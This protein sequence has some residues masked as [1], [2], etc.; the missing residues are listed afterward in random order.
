MSRAVA[1]AVAM[2]RRRF[3]VMAGMVAA[4]LGL[5]GCPGT[6]GAERS[7]AMAMTRRVAVEYFP[8]VAGDEWETVTPA[9]AG[10]DAGRLE[11]A[12]TFAAE[13][14]STAMVIVWGGRIMAERYWRDWDLHRA[15]AI[16]SCQ[17]SITSV[18]A[19]IAQEDGAL[20]IGDRVTDYLGAGW[21]DAPPEA[22]NRITVRHLLTMTSGLNDRLRYIAD[23]GSTWYY[24]TPAYYRTKAVIEKAAGMSMNDYTRAKLWSRI[25]MQD[26]LWFGDLLGPTPAQQYRAS[27]RDMAR[28]GL[29]ILAG[30]S[31]AG[32]DII[33]D[34]TYL[35]DALSTS[36]D[37]NP[38]YG[39]LWWLNGKERFLLPGPA[40]R[41]GDG[42]FIPDA[43]ADMV[44]A[45]GAGDKKIYVVPSLNLVV[46]RHGD[47]AGMDRTEAVSSFDNQLWQKLM[48]ASSG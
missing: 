11:E 43:P 10:W 41:G 4:G 39:Y 31:W 1:P 6:P 44:C 38:A 47:A 48:A 34:K 5:A 23:A 29:M 13:R 16:A 33:A 45:L 25:G 2:P 28:F 7:N 3:L 46:A 36:Q 18:L 30:G 20:R 15:A 27:A 40:S 14:N 24:N 9:D 17:K 21:C 42:S 32:Q 8:P 37:R 22:E 12:L 19:G 26:S 35:A